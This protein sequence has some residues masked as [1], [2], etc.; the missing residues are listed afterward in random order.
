MIKEEEEDEEEDE[1]EEKEKWEDWMGWGRGV[2]THV[3]ASRTV[4]KSASHAFPPIKAPK[5]QNIVFSPQRDA[6]GFKSTEVT[7]QK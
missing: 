2:E 6:H 5:L 7:G 3:E 1:Q 4:V